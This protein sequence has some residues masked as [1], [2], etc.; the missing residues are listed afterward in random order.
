MVVSTNRL[1]WVLRLYP[2]LLFQRVW[3]LG[4]S[5]DYQHVKVKISKSLLNKNPNGSIFGGT[6]FAAADPFLPVLFSQ[7]LNRHGKRNL[8]IWSRSSQVNFVKPALTDL[9]FEVKLTDEDIAQAEETLIVTG[10]YQKHFP[11][12]ITDASGEVCAS[13]LN[14]VYVRDLDISRTLI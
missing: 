11:I 7:V 14:E 1:K 12:E 8:K 10:K 3:V 9:Y 4:F 5:D 13:L 2:P 6:I